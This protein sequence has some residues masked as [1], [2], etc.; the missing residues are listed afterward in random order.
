MVGT[1]RGRRDVAASIDELL[2]VLDLE[3]LDD[4]VHRGVAPEAGSRSRVFGG[5]VLAQSLIAASRAVRP[6]LRPGS[7]QASF[8]R[9]GDPR[10]PIDYSVDPVAVNGGAILVHVV[11]EQSGRS[12]F[13]ACT[14]FV[15]GDLPESERPYGAPQPGIDGLPDF[16]DR[17]AEARFGADPA[18]WTAIDYRY[19]TPLDGRPWQ[20]VHHRAGGPLPDD[21][22]VHAAVHAYACDLTMI[23]T[24]LY[25]FGLRF[26]HGGLQVASLDHSMW[27]HEPLR[28]DDWVAHHQQVVS[29]GAGRGLIVGSMTAPDGRLAVTTAQEGLVRPGA[30]ARG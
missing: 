24:I 21:P 1:D 7:L 25:T 6:G 22:A 12:I 20:L 13:D 19:A 29:C 14:R 28:A 10:L 26:G 18:D 2:E 11:A 30:A 4:D 23:D 3:R 5:Q 8:L 15:V 9:P 27:F 16:A 17:V